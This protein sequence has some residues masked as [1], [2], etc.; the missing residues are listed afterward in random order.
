MNYFRADPTSQD[1]ALAIVKTLFCTIVG[2]F[3]TLLN[4][5]TG[6]GKSRMMREMSDYWHSTYGDKAVTYLIAPSAM[7]IAYNVQIIRDPSTYGSNYR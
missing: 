1:E 6:S 2:Y 5:G 4:S 7:Y 3:L